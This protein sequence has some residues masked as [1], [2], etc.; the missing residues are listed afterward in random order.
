M[1]PPTPPTITPMMLG[2]IEVPRPLSICEDVDGV[3][4]VKLVVLVKLDIA[5]KLD[6]YIGH[7]PD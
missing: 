7:Q 3:E 4:D 2:E 1:T 6:V 5:V